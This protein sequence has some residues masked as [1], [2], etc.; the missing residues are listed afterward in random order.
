[1]PPRPPTSTSLVLGSYDSIPMP[2]ERVRVG[3]SSHRRP[4]LSVSLGLTRHRSR[5]Y[6]ANTFS[7]L[8]ILMNWLLF[9]EWVAAPSRKPA[10]PFQPFS[11]EGAPPWNPTLASIAE[12]FSAV[13]AFPKLNAPRGPSPSSGCQ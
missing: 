11:K 7:R 8:F 9:P 1:M 13:T 12:G 2:A 3:Y 4:R 6:R 10:R 5:T